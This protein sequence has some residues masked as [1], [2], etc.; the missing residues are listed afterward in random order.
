M[1]HHVVCFTDILEKRPVTIFRIEDFSILNV[2]KNLRDYMAS[3][4]TKLDSF[5]RTAVRISDFTTALPNINSFLAYIHRAKLYF[6]NSVTAS[7]ITDRIY[8]TGCEPLYA[9]NTSHCKLEIFIY[10]SFY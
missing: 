7:S 8:N 5:I 6:L 3:P 10:V 1:K 9:T 2:G 4:S